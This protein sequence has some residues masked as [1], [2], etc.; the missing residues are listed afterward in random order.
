[1]V[2]MDV[3]TNIVQ[4]FY[5]ARYKMQVRG[6]WN[7]S[8]NYRIQM[9]ERRQNLQHASRNL[10]HFIYFCTAPGKTGRVS[11][12]TKWLQTIFKPLIITFL[13]NF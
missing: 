6:I 13:T 5:V 3:F 4:V 2:K 1:M 11:I 7:T 8:W 10:P 12:Q 9:F